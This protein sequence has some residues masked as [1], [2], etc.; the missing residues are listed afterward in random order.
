M[1]AR[2]TVGAMGARLM[3]GPRTLDPYVEVRI[4]GPQPGDL[5]LSY[6]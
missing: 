2:I 3:V 1:F 5:S 6:V 4:L